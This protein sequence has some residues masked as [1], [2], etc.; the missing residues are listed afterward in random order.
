[1]CMSASLNNLEFRCEGSTALYTWTAILSGSQRIPTTQADTGPD[2]PTVFYTQA[3]E[4][5]HTA[6]GDENARVFP[7]SSHLRTPHKL[8]ST[9]TGKNLHI[10]EAR[11][12][13]Q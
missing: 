10:I 1:M 4:S 5:S 11:F 3:T 9:D 6:G 12:T 8:L 7:L 2:I 13:L